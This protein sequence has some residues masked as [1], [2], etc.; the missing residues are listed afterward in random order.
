MNFVEGSERRTRGVRY[1]EDTGFEMRC[2]ECRTY[3]P[4]ALTF[5]NPGTL[6]RCRGC[7]ATRNRLSRRAAYWKN[8]DAELKRQAEYDARYRNRV[9]RAVAA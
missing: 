6:Q 8:R 4:L 5:W 7:E 9:R 2:D 1:R 3:W